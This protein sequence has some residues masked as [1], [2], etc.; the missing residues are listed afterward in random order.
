MFRKLSVV[1][2]SLVAVL[3]TAGISQAS[4]VNWDAIAQCESG[5]NW[6][7]NTGNGY[8]GGLQFNLGTW[9]GNGGSGNP[10]DASRSEQIRVAENV[11]NSQG[12]GAWPVCGVEGYSQQPASAPYHPSSEAVTTP[13]STH[14]NASHKAVKKPV[15]VDPVAPSTSSKTAVNPNFC[16]IGLEIRYT[17]VEGDTLYN[18]ARTHGTTWEYLLT[19]NP[20]IKDPNL[21]YPGENLIVP[22]GCLKY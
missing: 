20:Q 21:I 6:H 9:R 16:Y 10:A 17:V 12:L 19:F 1:V 18:I 14:H 8:Y 5:S 15:K 11:L 13:H 2:L 4:S 7:I 22:I 3:G